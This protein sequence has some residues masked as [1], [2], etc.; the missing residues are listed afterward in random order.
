[1]CRLLLNFYP[2]DFK[3]Q[4]LPGPVRGTLTLS[5]GVLLWNQ[6]ANLQEV[7]ENTLG[8]GANAVNNVWKHKWKHVWK[9]VLTQ[10]TIMLPSLVRSHCYL[11][12]GESLLSLCPG[13]LPLLSTR[14]APSCAKTL[15][16]HVPAVF[17]AY[18][19]YHHAIV[20]ELLMLLSG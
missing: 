17:I 15:C 16:Q 18:R 5:G 12:I 9:H 20:S 19:C 14:E 10:L 11:Y 13:M 2:P 7:W 4:Q 1:M 3:C 6:L 8:S